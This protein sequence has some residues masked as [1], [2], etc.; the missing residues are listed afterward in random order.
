MTQREDS[1]ETN[2]AERAHSGPGRALRDARLRWD[3]APADIAD[4]LHLNPRTIE[5]LEADDYENL[6]PLTFVRG[7]IRAYCQF[8]EMDPEPLVQRLG[9]AGAGGG[10][11][12][13]RAHAGDTAPASRP[14]RPARPA[15]QA[16]QGMGFM[17]VALSL[18]VLIAAL[19]AGGWWLSRS[20]ISVPILDSVSG[21]LIDGGDAEPGTDSAE[22][23]MEESTQPEQGFEPQSEPEPTDEQISAADPQ[24]RP[25]PEPGSESESGESSAGENATAPPTP[26][27]DNAA[28]ADAVMQESPEPTE[29]DS[30][31]SA[32]VLVFQFDAESWMEV[33]DASGERL[34]FGI[35]ESG[36]Q[37]LEGE[38]P[39]EIVVGNTD[40]VG[41]EFDGDQIDLEQYARGNVARFTLGGSGE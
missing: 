8:L 6:P 37:R 38:A 17:G 40:N 32:D 2:H 18:A 26:T 36:E 20:D 34:L 28:I 21:S 1:G 11:Q 41:L 16:R 33:T 10:R 7:Y 27:L 4:A 15:R 14:G 31:P 24:P 29:P 22:P 13:L 39:F 19:V 3:K 5:A 12:P 35:A 9:D 23:A 25:E 30:A